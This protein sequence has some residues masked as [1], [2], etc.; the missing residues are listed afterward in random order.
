M[1]SNLTALAQKAKEA[2]A[3]IESEINNSIGFEQTMEPPSADDTAPNSG[4]GGWDK[5]DVSLHDGTINDGTIEVNKEENTNS[6]EI[7]F[8]DL[9]AAVDDKPS[10]YQERNQSDGVV[11]PSRMDDFSC[12]DEPKSDSGALVD[13]LERISLLEQQVCSL[14]DELALA[15]NTTL[16]LQNKIDD[17]EEQ[18]KSLKEGAAK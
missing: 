3:L 2:A 8:V 10:I 5:C 9:K 12:Y 7:S 15:H 6:K 14:R 18:N 16:Q 13:A 17:L 1:W 4:D 11:V